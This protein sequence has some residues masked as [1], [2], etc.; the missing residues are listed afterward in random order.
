VSGSP[1]FSP[2]FL[3]V[4]HMEANKRQARKGHDVEPGVN[5]I[6]D[7]VIKGNVRDVFELDTLVLV[8]DGRRRP[9][10]DRQL[11]KVRHTRGHVQLLS[12]KAK[13][14]RKQVGQRVNP[15]WRKTHR[16]VAAGKYKNR[17]CN[18]GK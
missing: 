8:I 17:V 1:F 11:E 14:D 3:N 15:S 7:R 16:T 18:G 2:S 12:V 10:R 9:F 4:S 5:Y 6:E 13:L